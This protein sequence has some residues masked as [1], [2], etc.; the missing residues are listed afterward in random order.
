MHNMRIRLAAVILAASATLVAGCSGGSE[1]DKDAAFTPGGTTTSPTASPSASPGTTTAPVDLSLPPDVKLVFD[2]KPTGDPVEDK[3]L[4]DFAD[5]NRA[6]YKAVFN[7]RPD[8]PLARL[9]SADRGLTSMVDYLRG[10]HARGTVV[11]GT[12]RYYDFEISD[13]NAIAA[14]VTYC[15]DESR[16]SGK[17]RKTGQV[18]SSPPEPDDYSLVRVT[19]RM[20][21]KTGIWQQVD[22]L[23][24]QGARQCQRPA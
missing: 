5:A 4:Q 10:K 15:E 16:F 11:T 13:R 24:Q 9:Y 17:V 14:R 12:K 2:I 19:V 3:I 22:Y 6:K 1:G 21:A 7:N 23:P 18:L 8:D 20:N